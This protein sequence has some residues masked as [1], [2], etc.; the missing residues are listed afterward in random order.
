MERGSSRL[1][2]SIPMALADLAL[3]AI[4]DRDRDMMRAKGY[5]L[6]KIFSDLEKY[7][8]SLIEIKDPD[9]NTAIKIWIDFK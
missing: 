4:S 7:R 2:I 6:D 1:D 8:G 9:S 3:A 5:D